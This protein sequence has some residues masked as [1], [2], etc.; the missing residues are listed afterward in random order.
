M[1]A[2]PGYTPSNDPITGT[3]N[4]DGSTSGTIDFGPMDVSKID[5]TKA[6]AGLG[7]PD[8]YDH[9]QVTKLQQN[10][11][12]LGYTAQLGP[13]DMYGRIDSMYINGQ[14]TRIFD[15]SGNWEFVPDDGNWSA[16]GGPGDGGGGGGAGGAGGTGGAGTPGAGTGGAD[17]Q[18]LL[19][20][21]LAGQDTNRQ[22]QF[23]DQLQGYIDQYGRPVTPD[24][25]IIKAQTDAFRAQQTRGAEQGQAKL[26]EA[27]AYKGT[28]TGTRDAGTQA[29]YEAAALNTGNFQANQMFQEQTQRRSALQNILS[30]YGGQLT[31]EQ[32]RQLQ[33]EIAAIDATL[34]NQGLV[35]QNAQFY[36]QLGL[37]A[38]EQEAILNAQL[39]DK[40]QP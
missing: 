38:A 7:T 39:V 22:G 1:P 14:F 30:L 37:T 25:P 35:N 29:G 11:Q 10:L 16:W 21:M 24:D 33:S 19:A 13:A 20:Q 23:F 2:P 8:L 15:S 26:A 3:K 18:G 6:F 40:M 12:Q 28:P 5:K 9:T 31:A 27:N 36:D 17:L 4:P 34:R 32:T